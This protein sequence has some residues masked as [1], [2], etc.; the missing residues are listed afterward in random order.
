M[1]KNK[2]YNNIMN[3]SVTDPILGY[4]K[5]AGKPVERNYKIFVNNL[6]KNT[7]SASKKRERALAVVQAQADR[8]ESQVLE[9]LPHA[10]PGDAEKL[11]QL[12]G[13]EAESVRRDRAA[14]LLALYGKANKSDESAFNQYVEAYIQWFCARQALTPMQEKHPLGLHN[15]HARSQ[16]LHDFNQITQLK[17]IADEISMAI[18]EW[19][20]KEESK[21]TSTFG[22]EVMQGICD[23]MPPSKR[24]DDIQ[25]VKNAIPDD[26]KPYVTFAAQS[27][28]K[29]IKLTSRQSDRTP[30]ID[31]QF[32]TLLCN[33]DGWILGRDVIL[34]KSLKKALQSPE[35]REKWEYQLGKHLEDI[36]RTLS[37]KWGPADM[38]WYTPDAYKSPTA[39]AGGKPKKRQIDVMGL[40][41]TTVIVIECKNTDRPNKGSE[42]E[43]YF[44][45]KVNSDLGVG[46][47]QNILEDIRHGLKLPDGSTLGN[48]KLEGIVVTQNHFSGEMWSWQN[49][50]NPD[51]SIIPIHQYLLVLSLL[52]SAEELT[53]YFE[54][55]RKKFRDYHFILL[56]E[57]ELIV[58]FLTRSV[59]PLISLI[60][61]G[62]LFL[63]LSGKQWEATP[64][65]KFSTAPSIS[66]KKQW[67]EDFLSGLKVWTQPPH[68]LT[69]S[70][71]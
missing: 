57:L 8:L 42:N 58:P 67:R 56:D 50:S 25:K 36:T 62:V 61:P 20:D 66:N 24:I 16:T 46:Q 6:T 13:W 17:W 60:A 26:L 40:S 59:P 29:D 54:Q 12:Y 30:F 51:I 22:Q 15:K 43:R 10:Y 33:P 47:V 65:L 5:R 23:S 44:N 11:H 48:R 71:Q 39:N 55:R 49:L 2:R 31:T 32:G 52:E 35:L 63:T 34:L 70:A 37:D 38:T 41:D 27:A 9:A 4:A 45:S 64:E 68:L 69:W 1:P 7:K 21:L 14:T 19:V 18:G 53:K 28:P 3:S